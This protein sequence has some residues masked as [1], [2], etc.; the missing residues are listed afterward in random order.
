M[1]ENVI[2]CDKCQ[3]EIRVS[4]WPFCPHGKTNFSV[5]GDDIPGGV[6]IRHGLCNADG[7]PRKYY[8]KSE[9]A[10]EAEK[11]GLINNASGKPD[12]KPNTNRKYII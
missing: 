2:T 3:Q 7:T 1:S 6:W 10:K 9:M 4:D 5:I 12:A 11:R 8:S